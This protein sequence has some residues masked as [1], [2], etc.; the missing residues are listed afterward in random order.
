MHIKILISLGCPYCAET[1]KS[2]NML[3]VESPHVRSEMIDVAVFPHLA[4]KYNV[5]SV[6]STVINDKPAI[7]GA[8][9]PLEILNA[10]EQ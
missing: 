1:V 9:S 3:A 6:P 7:L 5:T 8:L 2:A 4:N 10:L